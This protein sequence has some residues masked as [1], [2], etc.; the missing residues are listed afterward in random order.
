MAKGAL[1]AVLGVSGGLQQAA[2][3]AVTYKVVPSQSKFVIYSKTASPLAKLRHT[4][5][6]R[7]SGYTG[8]VVFSAPNKPASVTMSVKANSLKTVVKDDLNASTAAR[9]DLVTE[10]DILE[11]GKYPNVTFKSTGMNVKVNP[12]GVYNGTMKGNLSLHG[13]TR[14]VVVPVSGKISGNQ[15][16][17]KGAFTIKQSDYG[18]TLISIMGGMLS[19]SDPV[20]IDFNLVAKK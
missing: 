8:N 6:L 11:A 14:P 20:T 4:R 1:V 2:Q 9:V 12:G 13:V 3:A 15:V 17:A 5:E 16:T 7:T 10:R 18:I 19:A